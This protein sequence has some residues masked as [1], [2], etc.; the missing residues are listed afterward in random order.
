MQGFAAI[1]I[2]VL[3]VGSIVVGVRL[4]LLH[5]RTGA[6]PE[7]LL[8]G[9]LLLSVGF[10]YSLLIATSLVGPGWAGPLQVVSNVGVNVGSRSCPRDPT[11][12]GCAPAR[13]IGSL[14]MA[15]SAAFEAACTCLEQGGAL[16]RLAA[17]GT[18]RIA[19]KQAG[20]EPKAVTARQL[21]VVLEKL[22]P[23]ELASRG[24]A[25]PDELCAR[26]DTPEAVF[27]RLGS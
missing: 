13:P 16:D 25:S 19:L 7:R 9:M 4:P 2:G 22:L 14:T 15:E 6:A 18:I 8:G 21:A 12:A 10:G 11:R 24:V 23:A 26:A 27:A 5:R 17:R 1:A 20:L 3:V